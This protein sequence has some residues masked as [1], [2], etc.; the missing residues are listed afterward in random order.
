MTDQ[1]LP[2]LQDIEACLL[3][4]QRGLRRR[5]RGLE[6]RRKAGLPWDRGLSVLWEGIRG[7]AGLAQRRREAVPAVEYPEDLPVSERRA[8]IADLIQRHQVVVLCGETGSGKS[9]QLPKICLDLGR[10]VAGRIGHTQP[11]RIAARSLASRVSQ[12]LGCELGSLVGYKVRFHDRVHP[13]TSIKLMTDGI[14]LAEIQQDPFLEEYDTLIIDEAH[15]RGLNIDFLLGYLKQLLP[16]RPDLRL[17]ITSATIDPERFSRHFGGA[18]VIEVS[19]RT[20]PVEVRY[21]P[22][23]EE[24]AGERDEEMRQALLAAVDELSRAGRGDILIFLSGEREIR[25]TAET[26][27]K[28][29][30]A[31]TEILPLYARL[32]PSEQARVFQPHGAR[33]VILATNV[34]ETSLTVPGIHYVIDPGFARISR[35]SHRSK[36]QRLPVERISRASADQRKGRCGRVAAGICIRLYSEDSFAARSEFTEPEILRTN[37][38]SV[39]LQMKLLGFG[40][41]ERFPFVDPPDSRL[42]SDGYRLLRELGA[43]DTGGD[44]TPLGRRLARLPVDPRIA[45]MLLAATELRCLREVLVIAAALSV[46]DPRERPIDRQEAADQIHA[47]FRHEDS[48]FLSFLNLWGFLEEQRRHLSNSKF[49]KLCQLHFLSWNRVQEWYDVHQQLRALMHEMGFAENAADGSYEE[50]HRSLLAGLLSNLGFRDEGREYLGARGSRFFVHPSSGQFEKGPKWVMAAERVETTRQY[51]RIVARIQPEWVERAAPHLIQRSYSEPHW[52]AGAGQVAAF[53]RVTLYG[54]PIVPR[55]RV[56]YGPVNPAEAR[57]IFIRFALVGGDFDTRAPFWRH[58]QELIDYVRHLEHKSRRR[59][60]L[61]DEEALYQFYAERIPEGV[62][63]KPLFERWLRQVTGRQPKLLHL[64]ISD[65]MQPEAQV[66]TQ[67]AFPDFLQV[68]GTRLP[69]EYHFDPG[70]SSDGVTLVVP[71]P[72]INQVSPERCEW[73][74]P[75]LLEERI[76]ALLRG[77]PKSIRRQLVPIPDTARELLARLKPA[78]RPLVQALSEGLRELKGLYVPGDAWDEATVPDHLRM[79]VRLVDEG[80]REIASGRAL[81]SLKQH[82]AS[83]GRAGFAR[84]PAEG[85]E[86]GGITR[87]DFATLPEAV[88]LERGGIRMRGFPAIVDHGDSV[89]IE[90]LDSAEN[91][92]RAMRKG[93]R[94]LLM[95]HL[96]ADIRYLRKNLP[97]L[98]HLRLQYAKAPGFAGAETSAPDIADELVA[99]ILDLTF[100]EGQSPVRDRSTFEARLAD[101]RGALMGTAAETCKLVAEILDHYQ[102][103][104]QRLAVITQRAWQPSVEDVRRQWD[105]L[106]FR[107]FLESIPYAQLR[108]YPRY[109]K[110]ALVRL[111]K[112]QFSAVQDQR[113][114]GEMGPL[115]TRWRE[116]MDAARQAGRQDPR[117]EE[118]RWR[119]EELRVSLFAQQIGTPFP[120]S[121]KRIEKR[122]RELGL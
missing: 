21:R 64:R 18:P 63:S 17:V 19:G 53:E 26:L 4:D 116:R 39:I 23:E 122:W 71:L 107:G 76:V 89:A 68:G 28:H 60:L 33:R 24:S 86:R 113:L 78:E 106:V 6:H 101:C 37:L 43:L 91:A 92:G 118:I 8:E 1:P 2:T 82:H 54:L 66:V 22:P 51:G 97:E 9:T 36:V 7:S 109:L 49:R 110:A 65:L 52:Q 27:R 72:L 55:R 79:N 95:M 85:L 3:R 29:R 84:V 112:L 90:V 70:H 100:L 14:L 99:V 69:L 30:L 98:N 56:N 96:G 48:D 57:E 103:L 34:A 80:G 62:Y 102:T 120:V 81:A 13:E 58:N 121:V 20:Y 11:R 67:E 61:V 93:L 40:E 119:L 5:L 12:E 35:Y 73:L 10:G 59:D 44:L 114:M 111:E 105:A 104:R 25:E 15:E 94:R 16:A 50:V 45:R 31:G 75:G 108:N 88:E 42:V 32:G 117:L 46:Q 115:L 87:W 41:I 38:A 47:T 83:A 77:L 74:V